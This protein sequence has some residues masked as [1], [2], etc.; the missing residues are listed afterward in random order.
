[1]SIIVAYSGDPPHSIQWFFSYSSTRVV[2]N[3]LFC[4]PLQWSISTV[5]PQAQ[6]PDELDI[7]SDEELEV[8]EWDDGDGWS[9]GKNKQGVQGYFPQSYVRALSRPNSPTL[10]EASNNRRTSSLALDVTTMSSV[11]AEAK[12]SNGA[13]PEIIKE[14]GKPYY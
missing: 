13:S 10:S 12:K 5:Y 11:P 4:V 2:F 8:I 3:F 9:K 6:R 1:M 14:T 7:V